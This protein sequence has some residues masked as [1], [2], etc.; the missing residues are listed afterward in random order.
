MHIAYDEHIK[1]ELKHFFPIMKAIAGQ[2]GNQC[3]AVIHDF[4]DYNSSIVAMIGNV[5]ERELYAP[6]TSF[7]IEIINTEGDDAEDKIGY[8]TYFKGKP[9]RCSTIFIR[10]GN[11]VIGCLCINYCVQ[12]FFAL[13]RITEQL[14]TNRSVLQLDAEA[15]QE[16]FAQNV[17]DFVEYTI[18]N[19]IEKNGE[20]LTKLTKAERLDLIRELE[21]TGVFSVKGTVETLAERMNMSKYTIYNDIEEVRR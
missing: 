1:Q 10:D 13:K 5:T 6:L 18:Q 16:Y 21:W 8:I 12:D 17:E 20:D 3:E 11:K 15:K 7:V 19:V 4:S 2:F 14:T 9:F